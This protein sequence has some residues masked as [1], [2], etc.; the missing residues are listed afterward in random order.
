MLLAQSCAQQAQLNGGIKDIIPP[1]LDSLRSTPNHQL[2]FVKQP[3]TLYFKEWVKLS[4]ISKQVVVSPPLKEAP[5][6][7][8]NGRAVVFT[9]AEKEVLKTNATYSIDFGDAIQDITEGNKVKV[10]YTFS[11]GDQL[12]SLVVR[13]VVVDA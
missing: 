10:H 3:I 1:K 11:T 8:L 2:R 13:G 6:V 4:D 9:F 7:K 12:D 5:E